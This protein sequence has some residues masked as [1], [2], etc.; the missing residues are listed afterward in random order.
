MIQIMLPKV[1]LSDM[2]DELQRLGEEIQSAYDD[3]EESVEPAPR[4][5]LDGLAELLDTLRASNADVP[6]DSE[7]ALR[8]ATGSEPDTLLEHG[9]DLLHHLAGVARRLGLDPQGQSIGVLSVPFSCWMLRRGGEL[10]HPEDVV[11][12]LATL[13]NRLRRPEDLTGLYGLMNEIA[14]GFAADRIH[15]MDPTNP[16]DPW[17]VLLINRGIVATRSHQPALMEEAFDAIVEQ[18]PE[19]APLFFREGMGQMEALDYPPHAREIMQRY[20]DRWCT[21]QRLH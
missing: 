9:L 2:A 4:V 6:S 12:A 7:Q 11:D 15:N 5:L 3:S 1:D 13:A 21:G 18:L 17:L 10:Q 8:T 20:Y 16:T 19:H 14:E